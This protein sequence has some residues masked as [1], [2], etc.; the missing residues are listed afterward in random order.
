MGGRKSKEIDEI[1][2]KSRSLDGT[3]ITG[4]NQNE[5]Y[6]QY[7]KEFGERKYDTYYD[8]H[9]KDNNWTFRD[10]WN[11]LEEKKYEEF[12][13]LIKAK[14]SLHVIN[15]LTYENHYEPTML[16]HSIEYNK[17]D[18]IATYLAKHKLSDVR[19]PDKL[20]Q[21]A[22]HFCTVNGNIEVMKLLLQR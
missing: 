1:N 14:R 17:N 18:S 21:T 4:E 15:N 5:A 9:Y 12:E 2:N 11:L 6:K 3:E 8:F 19:I 10:V 16:I 20:S 7:N 22:F 13:E